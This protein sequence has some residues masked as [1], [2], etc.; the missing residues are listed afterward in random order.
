MDKFEIGQHINTKKK[1]PC[2][3]N[4]WVIIRTGADIKIRCV[5]CL[6]EVMISKVQ[7]MKM[8]KK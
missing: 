7:L 4:E 8:I 6:R 1:H 3:S 2:G 5:G